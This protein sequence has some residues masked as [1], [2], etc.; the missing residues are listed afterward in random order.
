MVKC[1]RGIVLVFILLIILILSFAGAVLLKISLTDLRIN[2][3][4]IAWEQAYYS[5]EA[6][7]ETAISRLPHNLNDYIQYQ[8]HF[9]RL[10]GSGQEP[11]YYQV[12]VDSF[13]KDNQMI[14]RIL[15]TGFSGK[16]KRTVEV[17]TTFCIFGRHAMLSMGE[18]LLRSAEVQG[19][20]ICQKIIFD[21][22]NNEITGD[23]HVLDGI[24][25]SGGAGY[26]VLGKLLTGSELPL[27][28]LAEDFWSSRRDGK[29][30]SLNSGDEPLLLSHSLPEIVE[31]DCV[32]ISGDLI[33]DCEIRH[34]LCL[35]VSGKTYLRKM[36]RNANLAVLA[37]DDII[38]TVSEVNDTA[39]YG[40]VLLFSEKNIVGKRADYDSV[41]QFKGICIS[42]Q[43]IALSNT[44]LQYC[45]E[46]LKR[47]YDILSPMIPQNFHSYA[48]EWVD[49]IRRR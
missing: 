2:D 13:D 21:S 31:H 38:L 10:P 44:K 17:L 16:A 40:N 14:K 29:I 6:G 18:I 46:M 34:D 30:L 42:M 35:L 27:L 43:N 32:F 20:V 22:Y 39:W 7:A 3:N 28:D 24:E 36:P 26:S 8:A 49:P 4:L 48:H 11:P 47:F 37:K 9:E 41:L 19:H 25:S 23:L 45:E 5:A 15:S 1:E 12:I 33:I